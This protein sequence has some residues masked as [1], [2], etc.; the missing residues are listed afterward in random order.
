MRKLIV[1]EWITDTIMHDLEHKAELA[2]TII[3]SS[4]SQL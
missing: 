4:R 2:R 3:S 1:S